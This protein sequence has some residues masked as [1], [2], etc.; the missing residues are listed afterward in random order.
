MGIWVRGVNIGLLCMSHTSWWRCGSGE[1]AGTA[2]WR[3]SDLE[4]GGGRRSQVSCNGGVSRGPRVSPSGGA[5]H[6]SW[7]S[8]GRG[9][10][11]RSRV[12]H[13]GGAS[14][15]SVVSRNGAAAHR[16]SRV[17]CLPAGSGAAGQEGCPPGLCPRIIDHVSILDLECD[18]LSCRGRSRR[19]RSRQGLDEDRH[20]TV[21]TEDEVES[22]CCNLRDCDHPQA[23]C[24]RG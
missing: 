19:G 14:Q 4:G 5:S 15:R 3:R 13:N 21:L 12:S 18:G 11:R 10:S 2:R 23:A 1:L 9:A 22:E 8:C 20:T 7:V 17:R 6:R 16:G 24:Q